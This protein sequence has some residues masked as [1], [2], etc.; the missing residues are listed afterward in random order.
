MNRTFYVFLKRDQGQQKCF[1][2]P[3]VDATDLSKAVVLVLF[4]FMWL[5]GLYY[6]AF[7]V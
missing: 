6:R 7:D 1:K 3:V 5:R 2:P 4:L